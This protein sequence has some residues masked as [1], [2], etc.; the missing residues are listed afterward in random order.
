[1]AKSHNSEEFLLHVA[2][3]MERQLKEWN[4]TYEVMVMK[5]ASYELMVKE[6]EQYYHVHLNEQEIDTLQKRDPYGLDRKVWRELLNQGLPIIQ[7]TGNYT[8]LVL[9]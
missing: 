4:D 2:N 6:K 1:M 9:R 8:G 7:G 5:L 3:V